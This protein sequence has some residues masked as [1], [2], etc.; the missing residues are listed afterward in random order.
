MSNQ[1][2]LHTLSRLPLLTKVCLF[3]F[4]FTLILAVSVVSFDTFIALQKQNEKLTQ[5]LAENVNPEI[6]FI[7]ARVSQEDFKSLNSLFTSLGHHCVISL[8]TEENKV[9]DSLIFV[10]ITKLG[11]QVQY[12]HLSDTGYITE[13]SFPLSNWNAGSSKQASSYWLG[14]LVAKVDYKNAFNNNID[15][16][17]SQIVRHFLVS[18]AGMVLGF[19]LGYKMLI[20]RIRIFL[21]KLNSGSS[22]ND[23]KQYVDQDKTELSSLW[24]SIISLKERL[25]TKSL[26][27]E[28]ALKKSTHDLVKVQHESELKSQFLAK[29]SHELRT[30]MNG[31][32]GFST[33]L[34]ESKLE[35]EQKEYAQTIQASLESLLYVVNDVLDLSRIESGDLNITSIPFSLRSVISGVSALLKNRADAKGLEFETRIS[36]NVPDNLRGDPVRIRQVIMN[37]AANAIRHTDNGYVLINIMFLSSCSKEDSN[38]T[39]RIALED[40]GLSVHKRIS[41]DQAELDAG[42]SS[43]FRGR[44]SLGLDICFQLAELMGSQ[45]CHETTAEGGSSYWFDLTLPEL[46][47]ETSKQAIDLSALKKLRVLVIDSYELSRKITLELLQEWGVD[48]ET[49]PNAAEAFK[50]IQSYPNADNS[51]FN[52]ILCD[53]LLQDLSGIETCQRLRQV[54]PADV[55]IVVLCSNPQLGDAEGVFLSGANG[56]LSKRFRDPFL[57]SVICQAYAERFNRGQDKRLITRY[58]VNDA[59]TNLNAIPSTQSVAS[60]LIVESNIINQQLITN[61]L[62]RNQ[63]SVDLASNGFEAIELFKG[64]D[65]SLIFMDCGMPDMDG[66]ETTLIL[67]EIERSKAGKIRTPIIAMTTNDID[68]EFD[69]CFQVGMDE[70]MTKPLKIAK[71][72][73]VLGRYIH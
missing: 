4:F 57:S 11:Q 27:T 28:I 66:F 40:S 60:V 44:R 25:D 12:G 7:S 26:K 10:I 47:Q 58:T 41:K 70:L 3:S 62:E 20:K 51:A 2:A 37:L 31:L 54:I 50:L 30:P 59:E 45:L 8:G 38:V 5:C 6:S 34:L 19:L 9:N 36:A 29:M 65:Y 21:S 73:M 17:I 53:D 39:I 35:D 72:E 16:A 22:Y 1:E 18:F 48:F 69:K 42:F 23:L 33:L 64:N 15:Q 49:A 55:P 67:R 63:C 61:M 13:V 24:L 52:M 56:F 43:E 68:G 46:S 32:L 14:E 71:L